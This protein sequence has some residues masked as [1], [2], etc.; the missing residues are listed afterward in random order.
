[1][2]PIDTPT[3]A[4]NDGTTIPQLGL[5]VYKV[6]DDE[7]E[8]V[9]ATA[10]EA[11]YRHLDTASFYGNEGGVGRAMRASGVPRDDV[12]LTT[13]VWNTDHGYDETLR[14]FDRSL[15]TLGTDHV[16]LYLI[17]WPAPT[18]DRYVE[19]YRALERIR[20]EG[21]ARSIGVSNFQ[22]HHL[23]RL[24]GE[25]DVVPVV[26]Q[27]EVHPWLQQHEVREFA[28]AH[29]IVTQAWSPLARG[30]ILDDPTLLRLAERHGVSTAQ[31]VI[32]WHLQQGLVVIPKSVTPARIRSNIDVFGFELDDDDLA[33]VATLDSGQRTGSHPDTNG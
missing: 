18:Q 8:T 4:L 13:K 28:A 25:T 20:E 21:R 9:V 16:E 15:E 29:G 10:L 6:P 26:D 1:M 7:A 19:T 33:A 12:F 31:V 11:G 2:A 17:H 5:G 27:V 30:R 23:E 14:A 24:L 32:R 22:V 3:L